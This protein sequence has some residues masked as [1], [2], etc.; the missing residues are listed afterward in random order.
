[1]NM[2]PF[3]SSDLTAPSGPLNVDTWDAR[4]TEDGRV[5]VIDV[6]ADITGKTHHYASNV[7][8]DLVREER[9]PECEV[10]SLPPRSHLNASSN[11]GHTTR[12]SRG[13]SRTAQYTPVA[14]CIDRHNSEKRAHKK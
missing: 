10:R 1:M 6:I 5:S 8:R 7:Y 3:T 14:T 13:F 11:S 12:R 9:V 2:N 4:R